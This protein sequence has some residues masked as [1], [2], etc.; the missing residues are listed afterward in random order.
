M[1]VYSLFLVWLLLFSMSG[2]SSAT[3]EH[4]SDPVYKI[5]REREWKDFKTQG[6][7]NGSSDDLRDG[8]I[9]MSPAN[10]VERIIKKYFADEKEIYIVEFNKK[11][12]LELLIWEPASGGVMYPHLYNRPLK[13]EDMNDLVIINN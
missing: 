3:S 9:H 7:F 4:G 1:K 8:F 6:F 12:F 13:F 10:Q 11:E 2:D 5:L